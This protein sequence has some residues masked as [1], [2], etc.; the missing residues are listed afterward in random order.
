MQSSFLTACV[1]SL[2]APMPSS[3]QVADTQETVLEDAS[4]GTEL[5]SLESFG[6]LR[7]PLT[8]EVEL[9]VACKQ[10]LLPITSSATL[11]SQKI[12]VDVSI[13]VAGLNFK[14]SKRSSYKTSCHEL[15]ME[16]L[17]K[18]SSLAEVPLLTG[19]DVTLQIITNNSLENN[20][21]GA[22]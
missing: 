7:T 3:R 19:S 14:N 4:V 5:M 1:E 9:S 12:D 21:N 10:T 6:R 15:S 20:S 18:L 13:Y 2:P 16:M 11:T 22:E 17:L 8:G